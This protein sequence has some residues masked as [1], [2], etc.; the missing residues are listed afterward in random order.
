MGW[1][2]VDLNNKI[3]DAQKKQKD[4]LAEVLTVWTRIKN[5]IPDLYGQGFQVAMPVFIF[6]NE[7]KDFCKIGM[8]WSYCEV[9]PDG[10]NS[11]NVVLPNGNTGIKGRAFSDFDKFPIGIVPGVRLLHTRGWDSKELAD[12]AL[13]LGSNK[14]TGTDEWE[15]S[16][17]TR[18]VWE[19]EVLPD[20]T[21]LNCLQRKYMDLTSDVRELTAIRGNLLHNPTFNPIFFPSDYFR[22]GG[23]PFMDKYLQYIKDVENG[24]RQPQP[25]E[26]CVSGLSDGG[27]QIDPQSDTDN[28]NTGIQDT[29]EDVNYEASVWMNKIL[30]LWD[31]YTGIWLF[32]ILVI[33]YNILTRKK[34]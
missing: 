1:T 32:F 24:V 4:A 34:K 30:Y 13:I 29:G 10:T 8:E 31:R 19:N 12:P 33:G 22:N 23:A 14:V 27:T 25:V 26:D 21:Y 11:V 7:H 2:I 6:K 17:T 16:D 18:A 3:V 20:V 5:M 9:A 15:I 28:I